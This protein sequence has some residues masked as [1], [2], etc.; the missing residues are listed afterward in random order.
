M[1]SFR[2]SESV[3]NPAFFDFP[4]SLMHFWIGI[5]IAIILKYFNCT[6]KLNL[7]IAFIIHTIYEFFDY[8][9]T[10]ILKKYK[11]D[12]PSSNSFKNSIGD[13]ICNLVGIMLYLKLSKQKPSGKLVIL[14][15]IFTVIFFHFSIYYFG[16]G[17][18]KTY[19]AIIDKL[20]IS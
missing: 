11:K 15:I 14:S 20:N 4:W 3:R 18:E 12:S 9:H 16:S 1:L 13:T 8:Y 7:L 2:T 17:W 5:Q 6:D 10:Y 19:K